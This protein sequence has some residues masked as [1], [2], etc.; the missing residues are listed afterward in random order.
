MLAF[1]VHGVLDS[2]LAFTPT[3]LLFW[4][5]LGLAASLIGMLTQKPQVSGRW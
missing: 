2:F 5:M 1:L 4:M 3:A